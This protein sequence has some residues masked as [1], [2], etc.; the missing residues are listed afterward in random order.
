LELGNPNKKKVY[1]DSTILVALKSAIS[2]LD[3]IQKILLSSSQ[4]LDLSSESS[5]PDS[6]VLNS[7]ENDSEQ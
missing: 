6:E 3:L 1:A 4:D 2:S 7:E 5:D